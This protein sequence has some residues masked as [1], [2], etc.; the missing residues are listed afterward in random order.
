M[1]SSWSSSIYCPIPY[2]CQ[3][4]TIFFSPHMAIPSE[5]S[6][7]Q[8]I[9][10]LPQPT[11]LSH[12]STRHVV[13]QSHSWQITEHAPIATDD[14]SLHML[15]EG[16]RFLSH[17]ASLTWCMPHKC[18]NGCAVVS[19]GCITGRQFL[20]T[21]SM[22]LPLFDA[23]PSPHLHSCQRHHQDT[24]MSP[25]PQWRFPDQVLG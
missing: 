3:H 18:W 6:S 23:P 4:L 17:T 24:W 20:A 7:S 11:P 19:F 12:Y 22:P 14:R 9:A 13:L 1:S 15:R 25:P 5:S 8:N 2:S 16:P 10:D 21:C